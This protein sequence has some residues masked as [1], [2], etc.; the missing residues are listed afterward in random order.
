M[1]LG[2]GHIF[3]PKRLGC[4]DPSCDLRVCALRFLGQVSEITRG[5]RLRSAA[6]SE[7]HAKRV[8]PFIRVWN[9]N[10][11]ITL[12]A[13]QPAF[14][15]EKEGS[16]RR[17]ARIG[18]DAVPPTK[19][20]KESEKLSQLQENTLAILSRPVLTPPLTVADG[21]KDDVKIM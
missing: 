21:Y 5:W 9:R 17:N 19:S 13:H 6:P 2:K 1:L 3:S 7:S 11:E 16:V 15:N 4:P 14:H 8:S 10:A 12:Q 20:S 18:N